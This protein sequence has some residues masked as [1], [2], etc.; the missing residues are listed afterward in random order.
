MTR[1][2]LDVTDQAFRLVQRFQDGFDNLQVGS[3]IVSADVVN[4]TDASL[5]E[6]QVDRLTM[7]GYVQPVADIRAVTVYRK[8]L[9]CQRTADHQRN[10][11]LREMIWTVVIG[12]AGYCHR[13]PVSSMVC[14]YKQIRTRLGRRVRA[15]GMKRGRLREEEI[16]AV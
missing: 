4:L 13:K 9:V 2:I 5:V 15:G 11:L 10:Q 8:F 3:L 6:N 7:V 16:R 12:A 1:T 14:Q